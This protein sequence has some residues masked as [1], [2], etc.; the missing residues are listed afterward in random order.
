MDESDRSTFVTT[1]LSQQR[2]TVGEVEIVIMKVKRSY[3]VDIVIKAPR[4]MLIK[5]HYAPL[6]KWAT[7]PPIYP[8]IDESGEQ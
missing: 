5:K 7:N 3:S 6:N 8:P 1:L 2:I 4:K